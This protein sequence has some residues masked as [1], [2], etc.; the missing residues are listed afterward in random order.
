MT[1]SLLPLA[2][3]LLAGPLAAQVLV[4]RPVVLS[5]GTAEDRRVEGLADPVVAG[6]ALNARAHQRGTYTF[7]AIA[8]GNTWQVDLQPAPDSLVAGMRLRLL[9]AAGNT[10]PVQVS[11]NGSG[12]VPLLRHDG[13]P[14]DSG[15][16][17]GG[18][19][20]VVVHDGSAFQLLR[21][22]HSPRLDCPAGYVAVNGQYC[23]QTQQNPVGE[24]SDAALGCGAQNARLC[25]WM[26]WYRACAD[27]TQ[28][29]LSNMTGDWEWTNNTANGD[30]L[31]RV[32]GQATCTHSNTSPGWDALPRS[33]RCCFRR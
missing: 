15:Q 32:V 9:V 22:E 23:I 28:L 33:Y 5:G 7:A 8:G 6:D 17:Q 29:G 16:V 4:D 21:T 13:S 1:R 24:F 19:V 20:A 31:V 3:A 14:L 10:G 12:P 30:G 11:V 26:E 18:R 27:S 2:F 25:T